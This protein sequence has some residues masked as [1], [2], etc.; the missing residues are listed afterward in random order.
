VRR[1]PAGGAAQPADLLLIRFDLA[2]YIAE[3][4]P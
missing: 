3:A 2:G 1:D 4:K